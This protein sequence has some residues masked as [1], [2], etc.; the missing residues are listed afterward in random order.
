MFKKFALPAA[1]GAN[2]MHVFH[3]RSLRQDDGGA[4]LILSQDD[5]QTVESRR[6][7][8]LS[9]LPGAFDFALGHPGLQ[10]HDNP[11]TSPVMTVIPT[12]SRSGISCSPSAIR[13]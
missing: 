8:Q 12:A 3:A 9:Q 6:R 7:R 2:A 11:G 4:R 10:F 5:R 1:R 13:S